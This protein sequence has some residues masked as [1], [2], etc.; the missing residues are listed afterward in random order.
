MRPGIRHATP[1]HRPPVLVDSRRKCAFIRIASACMRL[2][3]VGSRTKSFESQ[4]NRLC[5]NS[6]ANAPRGARKRNRICVGIGE[7]ARQAYRLRLDV[8]LRVRG[9]RRSVD[10][11]HRAMAAPLHADP[12]HWQ[13]GHIL[14]QH[15]QQKGLDTWKIRGIHL[16]GRHFNECSAAGLA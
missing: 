10:Q 8:L 1:R 3:R 15:P 6:G 5:K 16:V 12:K 11:V 14:S 13:T 9:S 7:S 4:R 2:T